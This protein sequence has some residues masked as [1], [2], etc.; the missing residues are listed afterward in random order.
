MGL[1][2]HLVRL[3]EEGARRVKDIEKLL[4]DNRK[5][6]EAHGG[7]VVQSYATLGRYDMVAIL[8]LADDPTAMKLSAAIAANGVFR[9]ETL[10]AVPLSD[11]AAKLGR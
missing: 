2:I 6:I 11:F 8:E 3:T 5:L 9:P 7:R 4:A 10:T 1:Y